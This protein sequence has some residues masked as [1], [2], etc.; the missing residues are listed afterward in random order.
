[1]RWRSPHHPAWSNRTTLCHPRELRPC[2]TR[3]LAGHGE[4]R[5]TSPC[6]RGAALIS[7]E[8]SIDTS[9]PAGRLLFV[10]IAAL[11]QSEREE[12]SA[13]VAASVPVRAKLGKQIGGQGPFGYR[14]TQEHDNEQKKLLPNFEEAPI[15]RLIYSIFG[16]EK[17]YLT[18]VKIINGKG[19]RTR[20]GQEFTRTTVKRILTD[21]IY[22]GTRRAN[23]SQSKGNKKS[24]VLK[25]EDQWV[26]VPVDPIIPVK[27]WEEVQTII[28]QIEKKYP[29]E[30]LF[31]GK[32]KFGGRVYCECGEKMYV[33]KYNGM[34]IPRHRCRTCHLKINE[35][36]LIEGLR[37]GL[38]KITIN[39]DQLKASMQDNDTTIQQKNSEL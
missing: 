24:W 25:P 21:P 18:V 9:T 8:E 17:K 30:P 4:D 1:M 32:Y 12:I 10:V 19:F 36:V 6:W 38:K 29:G 35:D 2:P 3:A 22:K 13:R 11:A 39:P 23:Y 37:N 26:Y 34:K 14:W 16:K 5:I 7:L 31:L 15:V 33:A 20:K 28:S 27:E